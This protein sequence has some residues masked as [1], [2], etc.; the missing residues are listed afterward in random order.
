MVTAARASRRSISFPLVG[1]AGARSRTGPSCTPA[2]GRDR[3]AWRA[4]CAGFTL[5][6]LMIVVAI[7][8]ILGAFAYPTYA[9][10]IVRTRRTEG[11]VA[12][13]EAMQRQERYRVQ[14]NTYVA[15]SGDEPGPE[16]FTWWSGAAASA[17]AY[18]LDAYACAGR[19]IAECV[20]IRARPGTA[21]VDA[22][23]RDPACGALTLDSSGRQGAEG[24]GRCWP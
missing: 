3:H 24:M 19:D 8:G 6:E 16:G 23:F 9:G 22:R 11:Q 20:E 10:Y 2:P 14:H 12:L 7:V 21:R 4:W 5:V 17:S 15:F 1:S 13:I 18:E